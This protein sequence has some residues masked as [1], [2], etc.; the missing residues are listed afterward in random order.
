MT[1]PTLKNWPDTLPRDRAVEL[2]LIDGVI[3][4]RASEYVQNRIETLLDKQDISQ[5]TEAE[6]NELDCYG[7]IDDYLSFVNRTI[8]NTAIAQNNTAA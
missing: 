3:I 8:R 7:E 4:F 1:P 2:E 6:A 5:L